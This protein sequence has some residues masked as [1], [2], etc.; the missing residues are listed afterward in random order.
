MY[1]L[2]IHKIEVRANMKYLR[3]LSMDCQKRK[4]QCE[5]GNFIEKRISSLDHP[6]RISRKYLRS[7][8]SI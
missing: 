2:K 3:L 1:E 5:V 4:L 7:I 8:Q 6:S